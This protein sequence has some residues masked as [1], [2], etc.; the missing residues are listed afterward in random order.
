MRHVLAFALF[1]ALCVAA[2]VLL[3]VEGESL[4]GFVLLC[5]FFALPLGAALYAFVTIWWDSR[6]A[7]RAW[8]RARTDDGPTPAASLL[9]DGVEWVF[10][11]HRP[12]SCNSPETLPEDMAPD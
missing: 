6:Q 4:R 11:P 7:W 5:V 8:Q 9:P 2:K 3:G 10:L 1:V 12:G